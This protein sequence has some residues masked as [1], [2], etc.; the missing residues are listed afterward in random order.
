MRISYAIVFVSDMDRSI[1]FYRDVV[2]LPLRFDSPGWTEFSTDGATLALHKS[3]EPKQGDPDLEDLPPG[4]CRTGFQVPDID[5]F[6][7]TMIA[8]DVRCVQ[9]PQLVFGTRV[10]VYVDP[11]GMTFSIG[12]AGRD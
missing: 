11:D 4:R 9:E 1:K 5:A 7:A 12:E 10:A 3:D 6:H 8:H 2:G